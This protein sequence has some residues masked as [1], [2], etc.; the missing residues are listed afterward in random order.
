MP[1]VSSAAPRTSIL[2][3]PRGRSVP[4]SATPSTA[5]ARSPKG[6]LTKN[7]QR[8]DEVI[9]QEAADEGPDDRREPQVA[10]K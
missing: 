7:T 6:T 5:P 8:Q 4:A 1:A 2:T 9:G 3:D 10:E